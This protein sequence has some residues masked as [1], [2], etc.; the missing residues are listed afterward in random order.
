MCKDVLNVRCVSL[1]V[2]EKED[3][4][5]ES[6]PQLRVLFM[7]DG[8]MQHEIVTHCLDLLVDLHSNPHVWSWALGTDGK[9]EI[10]DKTALRMLSGFTLRDRVRKTTTPLC[11]K[12]LRWFRH[13][14]RT[15]PERLSVEVFW[16]LEDTS[17]QIWNTLEEYISHLD[18]ECLPRKR[19]RTCLGR[20]SS[21]LGWTGPI[22]YC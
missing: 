22:K 16:H 4:G 9:N 2:N 21:G 17:G 11:W 7:S 15:P 6:L 5:N 3:S 1:W 12:E 8:K 13:L 20:G 10:E 19:W 14:I 18:W